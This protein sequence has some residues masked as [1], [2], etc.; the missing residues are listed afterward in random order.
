VYDFH[1]QSVILHAECGVHTYES[2]FDT[3]ACEYDA[4]EC[5]N[6]TF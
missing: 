3:Y 1:K 4:Y 6:D 5:Y 2:D